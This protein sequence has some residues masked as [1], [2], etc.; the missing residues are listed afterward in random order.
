MNL[1]NIQL[2]LENE[3]S[4]KQEENIP[5]GHSEIIMLKGNRRYGLGEIVKDLKL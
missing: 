1:D 3:T 2:V 4:R 5:G